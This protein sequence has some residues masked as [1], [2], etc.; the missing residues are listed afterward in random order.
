VEKV[1]VRIEFEVN[2]SAF[3]V[4]LEGVGLVWKAGKRWAAI[5][6]SAEVLV[7]TCDSLA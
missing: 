6:K 4:N 5:R 2:G 1:S 3:P 7:L